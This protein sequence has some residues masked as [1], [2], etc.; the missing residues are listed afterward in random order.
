MT[1]TNVK[2]LLPVFV[3]RKAVQY[4]FQV[5]GVVNKSY[6]LNI[7][8]L[9]EK[10]VKLEESEK[11]NCSKIEELEKK[12]ESLKL[13]NTSLKG[14][15]NTEKL[16]TD[17]FNGKTENNELHK[18]I[19]KKLDLHL[20]QKGKIENNI[21]I[22]GYPEDATYPEDT[23]VVNELLK[24]IEVDQSKV[25]RKRRIKRKKES[26]DTQK[27]KP[28]EMIVVEFSDHSTQQ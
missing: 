24:V 3:F 20:Q 23:K 26:T 14:Q 28:L 8:K 12:M 5:N 16:M 19:V 7:K 18:Q 15:M 2:L 22:T 25:L 1:S 17:L 13:G 4:I 27:L 6:D 21:V 10:I 11:S 9:H